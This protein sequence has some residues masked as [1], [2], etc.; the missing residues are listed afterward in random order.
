MAV[1]SSNMGTWGWMS[2]ARGYR[3]SR[4]DPNTGEP[5]PALPLWLQQL[6]SELA[7]QAGFTGFVANACL[8]NHY[9]MG[10]GMGLHRDWNEGDTLEPI[11]SFSLGMSAR[12][13][14]GGLAYSDPLRHVW[15]NHGDVWVW[16]GDD[17]LRYHAIAPLEGQAHPRLGAHRLN[18][19][20]RCVH[21]KHGN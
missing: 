21:A 18:L 17:R 8:I 19:T 13:A 12:L 6:V 11:V 14:W 20:F 4:T 2:D 5:W 16:G 10:N 3:Y 9:R 7:A 1:A 15:L